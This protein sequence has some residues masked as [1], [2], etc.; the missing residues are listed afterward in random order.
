[1]TDKVMLID[2]DKKASC[3]HSNLP[4]KIKRAF[5]FDYVKS[6]DIKTLIVCSTSIKE[7]DKVDDSKLRCFE[8]NDSD[9][10][11]IEVPGDDTGA[12]NDAIP[13]PSEFPNFIS[14][15]RLP[16]E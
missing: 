2:Y 1:M 12:K 5:V 14:A 10:K 13:K 8:W 9:K 7:N 15:V 6:R 16:G 3:L 11:W 4:V